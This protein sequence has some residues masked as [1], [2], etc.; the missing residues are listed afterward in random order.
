MVELGAG[1]GLCGIAAAAAGAHVMLT[2]LRAVVDAVL[3]RN[4]GENVDHTSTAAA[5]VDDGSAAFV[6]GSIWDAANSLPW[7]GS[8]PVV[9]GMGGTATVQ[10]LDWTLGRAPKNPISHYSLT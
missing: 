3:H 4:I 8:R 5:R 7:E 10:T 1:V 9:G 6:S 2:D